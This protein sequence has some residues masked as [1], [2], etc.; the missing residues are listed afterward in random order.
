MAGELHPATL[1]TRA[2]SLKPKHQVDSGHLSYDDAQKHFLFGGA[3]LAREKGLE[4]LFPT[5]AHVGSIVRLF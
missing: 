2:P 5:R 3:G 1:L 4:L